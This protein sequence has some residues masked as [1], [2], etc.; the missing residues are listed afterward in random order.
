MPQYLCTT[1]SPAGARDRIRREAPSRDALLRHLDGQ[2]LSVLRVEEVEAEGG[3]RI[4]GARRADQLLEVV[5]ALGALLRVG[6][7]VPES[8]AEADSLVDDEGREVLRSVSERVAEGERLADAMARYP[9]WFNGF[10]VGVVRAAER[11]GDLATAF[12]RLER[13]LERDAEIRSELLSA[14][15]YPALLAF[16][17]G[18]AV[19]VLLGVVLPRFG[20]ILVASGGT[21]PTSTRLVLIA[22]GIVSSWWWAVGGGLLGVMVAIHLLVRPSVRARLTSSFLLR[23]PGVSSV[24]REVLTA[25]YARMLSVLLGGGTPLSEGLRYCEHAI[26]DPL[27]RRDAALVRTRVSEGSSFHAALGDATVFAPTL[28]RLVG[29]G[30]ATG[31]LGDFLERG[32][33]FYE[34]KMER[35]ARRAVA[36]V[37]PA[38]IVAFGVIVGFVALAVVQSIYSINAQAW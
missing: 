4:V 9:K 10:V 3:A 19:C 5:R 7:S 14:L 23:C 25:R 17:G 22:S 1:L 24:R 6:L 36:L 34:R 12:D 32:A 31:R 13:K 20:E 37:E 26:S 38:L 2:G 11:S 18:A 15:I 35:A 8:L 28:R 29:A 27:A 21:L 33:D 16:A 30:E